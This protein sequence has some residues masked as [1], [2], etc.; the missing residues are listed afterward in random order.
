MARTR[1][2]IFIFRRSNMTGCVLCRP[3]HEHPNLVFASDA[4]LVLLHEDW[5]VRG[6]L[7]VAARAHVENLSDLS[8][9]EAAAFM[10]AY[11]NAERVVLEVTGAARAIIMKLGVQVPHVHLHLYPVSRNATR[12]GIMD[13]IEGRLGVEKDD[14][15]LAELRERFA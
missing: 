3:A 13:A 15:L 1:L 12:S 2:P 10:A 14:S 11:R 4:A 8:D 5:A 6:H 9:A 7:V